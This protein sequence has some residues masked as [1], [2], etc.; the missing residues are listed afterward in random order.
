MRAWGIAATLAV[1]LT[2][3]VA[4]PAAALDIRGT[5]RITAWGEGTVRVE[6]SGTFYVRGAGTLSLR[7]RD[8]D[9]DVEVHGFHYSKKTVDGVRIY[10]GSGWVRVSSPDAML[11]LEGDID[12]FTACGKG[13]CHLGG[14]GFFR[15]HGATRPWPAT[16]GSIRFDLNG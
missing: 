9:T 5:G 2:F 12:S 3:A 15:V 1:V 4:S 16:D 8:G 10:Q 6:G 13:A 7:N 14:K 11:K